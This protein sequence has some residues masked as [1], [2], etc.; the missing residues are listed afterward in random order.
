MKNFLVTLLI[1]CPILFIYGQKNDPNVRSGQ[2][3]RYNPI[4][5]S[6]IN[7][8]LGGGETIKGSRFVFKGFN[9]KGILFMNGQSYTARGLNIDAID[10]DLISLVGTD[11][12]L[13][14]E[15]N[16]IDS[17]L[18]MGRKFKKFED[19]LFYEVLFESNKG[20]LLRKYNC[21]IIEGYNNVMKGVKE[22]DSYKLK[23]NYYFY[24]N[25]DFG[26]FDSNKKSILRLLHDKEQNVK[27]YIKD[28]NLSFKDKEGLIKVFEYYSTI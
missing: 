25:I 27:K 15:K 6:N 17:V 3:Y 2:I 21:S 7:K 4:L 23:E 5:S 12:V 20:D 1:L 19:D 26:K 10:N 11:S 8:Y 22:D 16:K 28:N 14:Y 13:V 18:I 24:K 9:Q